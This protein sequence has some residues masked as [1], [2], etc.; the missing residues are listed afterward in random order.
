MG[1]FLAEGYLAS[2]TAAELARSGAR[3]AAAS[4][5]A[6]DRGRV[7]YL[8]AVFLPA[9]QLCLFV[10]DAATADEVARALR[11]AGLPCERVTAAVIASPGEHGAQVPFG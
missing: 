6:G 2:A 7:R 1:A 11:G 3:A 5:S 4:A 8:G 9:D 10:F